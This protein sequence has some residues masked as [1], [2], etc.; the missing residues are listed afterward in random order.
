MSL[1]RR[2]VIW[3]ASSESLM[4]KF[5]CWS[6]MVTSLQSTLWPALHACSANTDELK[7][8]IL[9]ALLCSSTLL[10]NFL[11]V[12][13]T[14]RWLG[15]LHTGCSRP[16]LTSAC[17]GWHLLGVY[18]FSTMVMGPCPPLCSGSLPTRTST[19]TSPLT[20]PGSDRKAAVAHTLE[21]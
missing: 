3:H 18:S 6:R 7:S 19:W 16:R 21:T 9:T 5:S 1:L 10:H 2:R 20:T 13:P 15:T 12:S 11:F 14:Y 17:L 8:A 4:C